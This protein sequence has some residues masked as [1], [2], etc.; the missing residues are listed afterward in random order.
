M[1]LH[2]LS[3]GSGGNCSV[4]VDGDTAILIDAGISAR[5]IK[6]ALSSLGLCPE[7]L[8]GILI[9]HE[10]TDH[11]RGLATLVKHSAPPIFA[12]R[13]VANHLRRTI[14]GAEDY[15]EDLLLK[16]DISIGG[17]TVRAFPTPHDTPQSVGYRITGSAALGY[18]TD[19]GCVTR[20]MLA[21][22]LGVDA[23][24]I[25]ANHDIKMLETGPYP[26]QLKRRILSDHGHLSNDNCGR[27]AL[28]LAQNGAKN[29]VLAHLSKENNT[30]DLAL[31]TV[32]AALLEGGIRTGSDLFLSVAPEK[33]I[34]SL[35]F[36]V[37]SIC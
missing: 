13:T 26:V 18:C 29:I 21:G 16:T 24:L 4:V 11:I 33:D 2:T 12:P 28:M 17:L 9:T 14:T 30:P 32:S 25:E 22:L 27:L 3:S 23:A 5:A 1:Q 19:C 8:C 37:Y 20:E 6:Q 15:I 36:G 7:D 10:H 34:F 31:D 35:D